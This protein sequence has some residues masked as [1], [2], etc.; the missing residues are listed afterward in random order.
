MLRLQ[1][2]GVFYREKLNVKFLD[3]VKMKGLAD[4][5]IET[6]GEEWKGID[7]EFP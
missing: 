5:V 3:G 7:R 2:W 1:A 4:E 6:I